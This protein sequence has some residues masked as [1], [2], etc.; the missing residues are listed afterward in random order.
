MKKY[1]ES[2][3]SK[4]QR[5][6]QRIAWGASAAATLLLALVWGTSFKFFYGTDSKGEIAKR[7]EDNAPFQ[8]LKNTAANVYESVTGARVN[9]EKEDA[10]A[11]GTLEYVPE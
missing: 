10:T 7:S 3:R 5:H 4:P 8:V 2:L 9:F 11:T 6:K 1:I